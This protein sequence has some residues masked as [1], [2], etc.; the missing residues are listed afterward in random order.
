MIEKYIIRNEL[1]RKRWRIFKERKLAVFSS[2][3]LILLVG[4]TFLSP[5]IANSRPLVLKYNDHYYFPIVKDYSVDSFGITDTLD[6]NY[7]TLKLETSDF[8]LWP[9]VQWDP[10]ES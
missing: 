3:V 7:R 8:A 6:V 5:F 9:I 1:S 4:A 2:I 10:F